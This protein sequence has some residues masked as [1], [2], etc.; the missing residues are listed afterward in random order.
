ME[1]GKIKLTVGEVTPKT[2]VD[3]LNGKYDDEI[4]KS[5]LGFMLLSLSDIEDKNEEKPEDE[6]EEDFE[7]EDDLD[8]ELQDAYDDGFDDG[9]DA[10]YAD[11]Y[12]RAKKEAQTNG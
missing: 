9:Y 4:E 2:F 3:I 10:G 6:P 8:D 1:T 11:G 5:G 7:D 12:L